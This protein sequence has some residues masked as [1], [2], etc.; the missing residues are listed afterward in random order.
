MKCSRFSNRREFLGIAMR[1]ATAA[2]ASGYAKWVFA[3]PET[4]DVTELSALEA[5]IAIIRGDLKAEEYAQALLRR[6]DAAK[7]LNVFISRANR[8]RVMEAA[9]AADEKRASAAVRGVLSGVPIVVTDSIS[10]AALP[11]T[12]G[13][14]GLRN[15]RPIADAT[16]VARLLH[17]GAILLGKTNL[18]E[19]SLGW[20]CN[21]QAFG[22]VHNP[23]KITR[24]PGGSNGGT[25]AAIAARMAPIG[26]GED[27]D[28][29]IR[30]PAALC[31]VASLRP[32]TGRYPIDGIV[33]FSPT[34]STAGPTA[35][36]VSDL[37]LLDAVLAG[38]HG[39]LRPTALNGV[40]L[41]VSRGYYFSDLDGAVA[42][43][44]E[45]ALVKLKGAGAIL[46]E[47]EIPKLAELAPGIAATLLYYELRR[48]LPSSLA[49]QG[50]PVTFSQLMDYAS[51]DIQKL[52]TGP[53]VVPN[54]KAT[55]DSIYAN[56]I[57]NLRPSLQA[58]YRDYF[59]KHDLTAVIFPAV[60]MPAPAI[61]REAI[62]P[63]P[64][65]EANGKLLPARI[66]FTR[67]TAPSSVIGLPGLVIPAGITR[68]GLPVGLELD[69]PTNRD[70]ELLAVGLAIEGVL[71]RIP[72]PKA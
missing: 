19:L 22:R 13:T 56:A 33:P 67:N 42:Q 31:G 5:G 9:R 44:A 59:D 61:S 58:A 39:F 14:R 21:N 54:L 47:A 48:S 7:Y 53:M 64:D 55:P 49:A 23:Y 16:V 72:A 6:C 66:A 46:V 41:G 18:D 29:S 57:G 15:S 71:G 38:G 37:A 27:T 51:P 12:A 60:R 10:T 69:G 35:R 62:S 65:V 63:A 52:L 4:S 25:A 3:Q 26:L 70:R 20:T 17:E 24:V 11:T 28:G 50:A 40:R 43:I 1:S 34:L 36:S 2:L 45:Q 68:E 30:I 8:E 32:S